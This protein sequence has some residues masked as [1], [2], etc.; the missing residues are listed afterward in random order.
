MQ[1]ASLD[2]Y[3]G[4]ISQLDT[5]LGISIEGSGNVHRIFCTRNFN[6]KFYLMIILILFIL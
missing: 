4:L 6:P 1:Y 3:D 2:F 5:Y